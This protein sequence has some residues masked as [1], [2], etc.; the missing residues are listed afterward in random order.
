M[1]E[2]R[3]LPGERLSAIVP[4]RPLLRVLFQ[5]AMLG[6]CAIAGYLAASWLAGSSDTTSLAKICAGVDYMDG[7][8]EEFA[9][10]AADE[11]R[12]QLKALVEE[13][14]SALRNRA[15]ESD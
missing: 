11:V 14:Q 8:Q 3:S 9:G 10:D 13:C 1:L 12:E 2:G 5:A 6:L 7:L 4:S 15:E